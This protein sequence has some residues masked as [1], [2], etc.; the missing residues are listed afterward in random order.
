[1]FRIRP[2]SSRCLGTGVTFRNGGSTA[3]AANREVAIMQANAIMR[4]LLIIA[5][6][7]GFWA[8]SELGFAL[9]KHLGIPLPGNLLGM[10][11]LFL[12]LAGGVVKLE[13]LDAGA[14]F[15][16]RH[17][18]FCFIPIAVGLMTMGDLIRSHGIAILAVLLA[19]AAAGILFSG[20]VVQTL[21]RERSAKQS[22]RKV[23]P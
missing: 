4:G 1:M 3:T 8:I 9:T 16:L 11:M 21:S 14:T 10:V 22:A 15:L 7:S 18:A 12:L 2:A 6:A 23:A 13:W 20:L 17:L 19:S 5:Q